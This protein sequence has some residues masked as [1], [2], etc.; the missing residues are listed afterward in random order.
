[1]KVNIGVKPA[2]Y[3]D[4]TKLSDVAAWNN[5]GTE[6][7]PPRPVWRIAAEKII[8]SEE[9]KKSIKAY[10]KN[11]MVNPIK[12]E[13]ER[14]EAEFLRKIGQQSA[15]EA[16]RI[17]DGGGGLQHNAPATVKKKGFDKPLYE[18]GLLIKNIDY[19][20]EK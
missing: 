9:F 14:L 12:T 10:F 16:K 5:Y 8:G 2:T 1:M 13:H 18:T 20:I 17:I 19:E 4:G 11:I 3:K 7:I 15:A 6:T